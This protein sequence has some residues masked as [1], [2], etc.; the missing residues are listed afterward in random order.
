TRLD[1]VARDVSAIVMGTSYDPPVHGVVVTLT[2]DQ[3]AALE[4]K[5]RMADGKILDVRL[6]GTMLSAKLEDRYT[7]GLIPLSPT[8]FYFPL[9][10]GKA[11]FTL[12]ENGKAAKINMRYSGEDHVAER[13]N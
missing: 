13:V 7:A 9:G 12:G 8:E 2:R 3:F 11:M 5:Y 6:D 10:D 1:R 4:G